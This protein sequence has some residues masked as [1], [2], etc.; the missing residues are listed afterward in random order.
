MTEK[1]NEEFLRILS[2]SR[3]ER[4]LETLYLRRLANT[5]REEWTDAQWSAIKSFTRQQGDKFWK[6]LASAT[7]DLVNRRLEPPNWTDAFL[8]HNWKALQF[9]NPGNWPGLREWHPDAVMKLLQK[10]NLYCGS[11][12]KW[13][14][15]R[16]L[17]LGLEPGVYSVS[18]CP[19]LTS[20]QA[21]S[22]LSL[23]F[24]VRLKG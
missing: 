20:E 21:C 12:V 1:E 2:D 10:L 18:E 6:R 8:S 11:D 7:T 4:E 17:T 3:V 24:L 15:K 22:A 9:P 14:Q 19:K 13:Y 23:P 16:R 5:P